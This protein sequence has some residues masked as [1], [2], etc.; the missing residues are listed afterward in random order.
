MNETPSSDE[1]TV[2]WPFIL[3]MTVLLVFGVVGIVY[4]G[5]RDARVAKEAS[6]SARSFSRLRDASL[7]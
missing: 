5:I 4:G 2:D 6:S 1:A 7:A 3:P